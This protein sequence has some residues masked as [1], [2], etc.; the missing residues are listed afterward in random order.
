MFGGRHKTNR[1]QLDAEYGGFHDLET[2][3]NETALG[4]DDISDVD[5]LNVIREDMQQQK[6]IAEKERNKAMSDR[7]R[8]LQEKA[9]A[10]ADRVRL[11]QERDMQRAEA[12]RLR[13]SKNAVERELD[14]ERWR[15]PTNVLLPFGHTSTLNDYYTKERLKQEVKDDLL[16]EHKMKQYERERDKELAKIWKPE[17]KHT[18]RVKV[19]VRKVSKPRTRSKSKSSSR[20]KSKSASRSK[21]KS[22]KGK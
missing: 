12:D 6:Q 21:S 10:D 14:S 17:R 8:A 22:R 5:A 13:V 1:R 7:Q 20:S 3:R 4:P 11:Q 2:F 19:I 16:R 15:R 9:D 18:G